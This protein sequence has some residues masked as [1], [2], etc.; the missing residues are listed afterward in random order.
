MTAD[1][2][3]MLA[4][5]DRLNKI[6]LDLK[7]RLDEAGPA[8]SREGEDLFRLMFENHSAIML[9]IDPVSRIIVDANASA[10]EFYGYPRER[11][12]NMSVERINAQPES[13]IA[14]QRQQAMQG[15][16]SSFIFVHRLANN[17]VRT[18]EVYISTVNYRGRML[19]FSIIHDITERRLAE[20]QIRNLAFYDP[21]TGLSNRRLLDDRLTLALQ[22]GKRSGRHAVLMLLDL[23]NFKPLNDEHG[24]ALGDLL[25]VDVA[26]R[27]RGCVREID[28]LSRIGGDEFVVMLGEL[29]ADREESLSLARIVAEKVRARLEEPHV[30]VLRGEGGEDRSVEYRC[31]SSIG[32]VLFMRGEGNGEALLRRADA[33]MYLAKQSGGNQV[34]F[35]G[36]DDVG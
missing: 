21:L 31:T 22:A 23:D 25:L 28:T 8:S 34:R 32:A 3:K 36:T 9:L 1:D 12:R 16:R 17:D 26:T 35:H 4:E 14:S 20:E 33:A 2:Q 11:L 15:E 18:V 7:N 5:I 10:A 6:I 27:L 13:E 29:A 30:L 24:H 19:F